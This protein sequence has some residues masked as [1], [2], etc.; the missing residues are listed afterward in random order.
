MPKLNQRSLNFKNRSSMLEV[1][2]TS[3]GHDVHAELLYFNV[4]VLLHPKQQAWGEVARVASV[5]SS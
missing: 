2:R 4:F 1:F 3:S 5:A